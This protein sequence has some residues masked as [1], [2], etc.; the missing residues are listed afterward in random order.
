MAFDVGVVGSATR[1]KH[2]VEAQMSGGKGRA[3]EIDAG[4][5]EKLK[6]EVRE[7][8]GHPGGSS[9][10]VFCSAQSYSDMKPTL[11]IS[12]VEL[13]W[14]MKTAD[15][16]PRKIDRSKVPAQSCPGQEQRNPVLCSSVL[17]LARAS[18]AAIFGCLSRAKTGI[19]KLGSS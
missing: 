12:L 3:T 17:P 9:Y 16:A 15:R 10:I 18:L 7:C 11:T 8:L 6:S 2:G 1:E 5:C 14:R 13:E 19:L 4:K